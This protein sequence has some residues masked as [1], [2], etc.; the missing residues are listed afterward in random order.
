MAD[1]TVLNPGAGG[2]TC[3]ADDIGG[4]KYQRVKLVLGADGSNDGDLAS[5]NPLPVAAPQLTAIAAAVKAEDAAHA[6]GDSGLL[7]LA[8]RRDIDT[9]A[10]DADGDFSTLLTDETGRLKVATH[11]GSL[12]SGSGSITASGQSVGIDVSRASNITISLVGTS[13]VGHN[14]T[15][16]YSPD[17]T[18]GTNGSWYGIQVVRTNANTIETTTGVLAA[19][20]A[21][22]WEASVNG[23][24]WVRVRATAHTSGTA[25]YIIQPASYATEPIPAAQV[26]GTQPVS[27]SLTSAGTTT[28]TPTTPTGS[29][30]NSAASTNATSVKASAGTL[31]SLF[32]SNTGAAVAYVKIYNKASAPTVGTDT[33]ILV[34]AVPATGN[35]S[36]NLGALGH[37]LATGI[38]LAITTGALD[39]DT[40]AVA[41]NQVKALVSY[42]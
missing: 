23:Y 11:P 6:S 15:F 25:A 9:A 21:Y 18:N 34:L 2:D 8:V 5:G 13:L 27:G 32:A 1:N 17:S 3:A 31:Y 37:R 42:L 24:K 12:A 28:N 16:E 30:I 20:P 38:A 7:V 39:S 41:A 29:T 26:S 14:A 22:G 10:V 35:A 4:V 36:A 19:T 40:G 33:P